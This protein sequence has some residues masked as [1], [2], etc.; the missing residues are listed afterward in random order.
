[1]QEMT[2][3]VVGLKACFVNDRGHEV[4]PVSAEEWLGWVA[5]SRTRNWCEA[6]PLLDWLNLYGDAAGFER[7]PEP[8]PRTDFRA[9]IFRQGHAFEAAVIAHL[10]RREAVRGMNGSPEWMRSAAACEETFAAMERGEA[11]IHQGL[12]RN[13]ENRTYGAPDLLIRS[14]V[15]RRLFPDSLTEDEARE[16][17][18]GLGRQAWHYRVVDVKFTNLKFDRRWLAG[19]KHLAYMVQTAIYNE[20]LGRIQ[21]YE[22]PLAYL[23]GRGWS[24]GKNE[25]GSTSSMDRLAAVPGDHVVGD[26]TVREHAGEAVA[27]VRRLRLEGESWD[28]GKRPCPEELLPNPKSTGNQPWHGAVV[29]LARELEDVTLAWQVGL[30]GRAQAKTAGIERWT[31][32]RFCGAAVGLKG[33]RVDVLDRALSI[34]RDPRGPSVS[35]RRI[36][37]AVEEWGEARGVE[38]FVDFETV[39]SLA[40]DFARMPEQNG[41]PLIFM[42]GCGHIEDGAW[43]FSCFVAEGLSVESEATI[44]EA[45][46]AHMEAVRRRLAPEVERPLVFHWSPAETAV[47]S[48]LSSA[49][50]RNPGRQASWLEPNWFDFLARVM[51]KEP[52]IVRGPMGFGLKTVARSLRERGLIETA[53]GDSVTDGLGAM[54]AAWWCA[55]EAAR[56]GCTLAELDL[57]A[58]VRAY[59]EVD[60]RVMMEAIAYLRGRAGVAA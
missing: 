6:D 10:E 55:E 53:W 24:K 56:V 17:A 50:T 33:H 4:A 21:G 37:A 15:L 7:D 38:F 46:L 16:G 44:V 29:G 36:R 43:R 59:N 5:A 26:R 20:A 3:A 51:R 48:G 28:P 45:W 47:F 39:S 8:D 18:P 41:Q 11:I 54:V 49:R 35:P 19:S 40:D 32:S 60:C 25:S 9:F 31:D 58:D 57:M 52:V 14:D 22:P 27:W 42:I 23:L 30:P 12:L 13:P 34:N 1:M 2:T